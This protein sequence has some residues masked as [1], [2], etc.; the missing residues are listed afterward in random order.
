MSGDLNSETSQD[1]SSILDSLSSLDISL[2]SMSEIMD[3]EPVRISFEDITAA[4][5]RIRDG[6]VK[7]L[8]EVKA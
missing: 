5:F 4:S 7:T 8:C 1:E 3:K 2:H 6:I